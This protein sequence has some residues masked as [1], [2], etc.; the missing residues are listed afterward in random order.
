MTQATEPAKPV[1]GEGEAEAAGEEMNGS[2]AM[3]SSRIDDLRDRI[4][5][6]QKKVEDLS[7][8]QLGLRGKTNKSIVR[9]HYLKK[10]RSEKE[11]LFKTLANKEVGLKK[12]HKKKHQNIRVLT[13]KISLLEQ[14]FKEREEVD[15]R[16]EDEEREKILRDQSSQK[17]NQKGYMSTDLI[18]LK[19]KLDHEIIMD[20]IR[21]A[22]KKNV[23]RSKEEQEEQKDLIEM[24][25]QQIM[26]EN[27][28]RMLDIQFKTKISKLSVERY[29][30]Q[31]SL[32][33][34][35]RVEQER[36][37]QARLAKEAERRIKKLQKKTDEQLELYTDA[38]DTEYEQKKQY[39][40]MLER[41]QDEHRS[42]IESLRTKSQ[43]QKSLRES[44]I[45]KSK[46]DL[47]AEGEEGEGYDPNKSTESK[48][49]SKLKGIRV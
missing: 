41:S 21:T 24:R 30:E 38:K 2:Q 25:R 23:L 10:E 35:Q 31:I 19:R 22:K 26:Q 49:K 34:L 36:F 6:V 16:K 5:G 40:Q 20:S 33:T 3:H 47:M 14:R 44:Q 32:Q 27:K 13:Q 17:K 29:R 4:E 45:E 15:A 1:K 8:Y 9:L 18:R 43:I 48:K 7:D 12:L 28:N 37:E 46:R 11:D 39:E 42:K